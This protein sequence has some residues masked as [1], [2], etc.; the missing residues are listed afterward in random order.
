MPVEPTPPGRMEVV[1]GLD[2]NVWL[3]GVSLRPPM[4]PTLRVNARVRQQAI[5]A[6][7]MKGVLMT[8]GGGRRTER[9]GKG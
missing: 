1:M 2:E 3:V 9:H 5:A 6:W 4:I 7:Q 8:G